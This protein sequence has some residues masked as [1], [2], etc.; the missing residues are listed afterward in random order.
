MFCDLPR[1][2]SSR[3]PDYIIIC[4]Y[5]YKISCMSTVELMCSTVG[6]LETTT[7]SGVQ[8]INDSYPFSCSWWRVWSNHW[9]G[10][11]KN[12]GT[13]SAER[14]WSRRYFAT[15]RDWSLNLKFLFMSFT[16]ITGFVSCYY[17]YIFVLA[18]NHSLVR[19]PVIHCISG[20]WGNVYTTE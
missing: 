3:G 18:H 19:K 14:Y 4:A 5:E 1:C 2:A 7:F 13:L 17:W 12:G 6:R 11:R 20:I 8:R 16:E 10:Y 9:A 15:D